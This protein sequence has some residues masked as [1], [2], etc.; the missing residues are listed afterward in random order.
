MNVQTK[1]NIGDN[2]CT[3]NPDTLKIDKFKITHISVSV[4][5]DEAIVSYWGNGMNTSV[6]E[7]NLFNSEQDLIK[8]I[9]APAE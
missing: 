2:V 5:S 9:A 4:F 3:I 6:K 1:F 8:H 7:N